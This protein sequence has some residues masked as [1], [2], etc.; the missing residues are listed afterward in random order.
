[1]VQI[2]ESNICW[3]NLLEPENLL[4]YFLK[5]RRIFGWHESFLWGYWY[6]CFGLLVTSTPRWQ[7]Q[8]GQ[9]Y[10][11]TFPDDILLIAN[12]AVEPLCLMYLWAGIGGAQNH[13]LLCRRW[14]LDS[15]CSIGSVCENISW[16]SA[17]VFQ[18]PEC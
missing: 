2:R 5:K 16:R 10:L 13:Y 6:S 1:M 7:S 18:K 15:L 9:L 3:K 12:M 11:Y 4:T 17:I 8:R 14:M